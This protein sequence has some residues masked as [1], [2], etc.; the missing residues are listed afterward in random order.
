MFN[1][2]AL[3]A[4]VHRKYTELAKIIPKDIKRNLNATPVKCTLG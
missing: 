4:R 3:P 2:A 1:V